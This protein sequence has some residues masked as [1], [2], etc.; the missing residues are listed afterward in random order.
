MKA[1]KNRP[2][3]LVDIAVPRD[4]DPEV[5]LMENVYVY[6]IDD[7]QSIADNYLEQRKEEIARCE[8]II[9]DK[10]RGLA[11]A[12]GRREVGGIEEGIA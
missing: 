3:L 8:Q 4:I 2:L 9:R 6:N 1:R 5:N 11:E 7:L 10:V 12:G